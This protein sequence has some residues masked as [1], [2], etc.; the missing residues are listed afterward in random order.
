MD[1]NL[2]WEGDSSE[3]DPL[4]SASHSPTEAEIAEIIE[5]FVQGSLT[6]VEA[7][8]A[9]ER[10]RRAKKRV[11]PVVVDLCRSPNPKLYNIGAAL[12][13]E[14]KLT[15]AKNPL[16]V[17]VENPSLED[18]HKLALLRALETIGGFAPG[19]NPFSYLRDPE[20][21]FRRVVDML[22][23]MLYDPLE[24][25]RLLEE[26]F[27]GG[28]PHLLLDACM[29]EGI[30]STHDRRALPLF[31]CLLHAPD[32]RT[33]LKA[34]EGLVRFGDP[35]LVSILEERSL[36]D[37]SPEVRRAARDAI[38]TLASEAQLHVLSI[39]HLPLAPPSI[40]RCAIS[41][42]DGRGAQMCVLIW[43]MATDER[44]G[45]TIL[46]DDQEG[47]RECIIVEGDKA[48]TS[49]EE[50]L[51][52]DFEE[53]GISIRMI[54]ISLARARVEL[55]QAYQ[56]TLRAR[57]RV[58][59]VYILLRDWLLGDDPRTVDYY[60]L[61]RV[62]P[63]EIG[64]LLQ[65][66]GELFR[67]DEFSSWSFDFSG[68]DTL[69]R[70][71]RKTFFLGSSEEACEG[72]ISQALQKAVSPEWRER[73]RRRLERQAWLLTQLYEEEDIPK[74]ALAASAALEANAGVPLTEHPFLREMMRQTLLGLNVT[75]I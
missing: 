23:T 48:V 32:D 74:M 50:A 69:R 13:S 51:E 52:H 10:L 15:E 63:E 37:P 29:L 6:N 67:L 33:V 49:L 30:A 11:L 68:L 56:T 59:P 28:A 66:S 45:L 73:I 75:L 19:E 27:E 46:F 72:L 71:Y 54:E 70:K 38:K 16:R 18:E 5:R 2:S 41:A 53:A 7:E 22:F 25:S 24:L 31:Q 36:Y 58:P 55:E 57:R 43:R 21:L 12:V 1:H 4:F 40:E 34:I 26:E 64:A 42:I 44:V 17:L 65:R 20:G 3:L 60:P 14:I 62:Q 39:F 61:A 9:F 35:S 8:A 47:I